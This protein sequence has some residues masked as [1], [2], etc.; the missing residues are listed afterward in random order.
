MKTADFEITDEE[1]SK[2]PLLFQKLR[3]GYL[4]WKRTGVLPNGVRLL[5]GKRISKT[6]LE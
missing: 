3:A 5:D 1:A 4:E 6:V 2:M